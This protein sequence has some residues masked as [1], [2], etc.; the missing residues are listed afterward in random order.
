MSEQV[1]GF[2]A[3]SHKSDPDSSPKMDFI[4]AVM[5]I[6]DGFG[7]SHFTKC[8]CYKLDS[9]CFVDAARPRSI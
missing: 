4:E 7:A 9:A 8:M 5:S 1:L 2:A 6:D 3:N